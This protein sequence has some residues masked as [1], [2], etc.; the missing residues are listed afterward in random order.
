MCILLFAIVVGSFL[1]LRHVDKYIH[2]Q[3]DQARDSYVLADLVKGD[4]PL[5]G[6]EMS[7]SGVHLPPY[8]YY[9]LY[10]SILISHDPVWHLVPNIFFSIFTIPLIFFAVIK[11]ARPKQTNMY[12]NAGIAAFTWSIFYTDIFLSQR[13][14]NPVPIP[15]FLITFLLLWDSLGREKKQKDLTAILIGLVSTL[16]MSMHMITFAMVIGF[17]SL[18]VFFHK[19]KYYRYVVIASITIVILNI[20]YFYNEVVNGQP[21]INLFREFFLRHLSTNLVYSMVILACVIFS[22]VLIAIRKGYAD[23]ISKWMMVKANNKDYRI[24]LSSFCALIVLAGIISGFWINMAS[25]I[26]QIN[27]PLVILFYLFLAYGLINLLRLENNIL[28]VWLITVALYCLA[29]VILSFSA[30]TDTRYTVYL[31]IVPFLTFA[32]INI[33]RLEYK[34]VITASVISLFLFYGYLKGNYIAYKNL[35]ETKVGVTR[36]LNTKDMVEIMKDMK[37]GETLCISDK[38][39]RLAFKYISEYVVGNNISIRNNCE[40]N[41]SDYVLSIKDGQKSEYDSFL[42]TPKYKQSKGKERYII[43]KYNTNSE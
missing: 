22:L 31:W 39:K 10:P 23:I 7:I 25:E 5:Q 12:I 29:M 16:L 2:F 27:R 41:S 11:F 4:I 6:P 30:K 36:E 3:N 8:Y 24:V 19:A 32:N 20:P 26:F 35:E 40:R 37:N 1:R 13:E 9:M 21:N 14:W 28:R 34:K 15:F 18:L 38:S 33:D 42:N 43:L 17:F